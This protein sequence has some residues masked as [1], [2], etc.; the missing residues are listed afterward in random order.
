[1]R[2]QWRQAIRLEGQGPFV[3][4]AER[5]MGRHNLLRSKIALQAIAEIAGGAVTSVMCVS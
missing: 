5:G 3:V 1:M 4:L 2:A